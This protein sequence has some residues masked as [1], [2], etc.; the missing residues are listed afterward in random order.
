MP[1]VPEQ[2][3]HLNGTELNQF[4]QTSLEEHSNAI[5]FIAAEEKRV[6]LENAAAENKAAVVL[7][8]KSTKIKKRGREIGDEIFLGKNAIQEGIKNYSSLTNAGNN[9]IFSLPV[10]L[11]NVNWVGA[12]TRKKYNRAESAEVLTTCLHGKVVEACDECKDAPSDQ[13]VGDNDKIKTKKVHTCIHGNPGNNCKVCRKSK[14]ACP[15]NRFKSSCISCRGSRTC[16]HG[17]IKT[18]CKECGGSAICTHNRVK[19]TCKECGGSALCHH[20]RCKYYCKDCGGSALCIHGKIKRLCASCGGSALCRHGKLKYICKQCGIFQCQHGKRGDRC[21][22]C[23]GKFHCEH[24]QIRSKCELCKG[25]LILCEH[26]NL[27][28]QCDN[29]AVIQSF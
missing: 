26:G 27:K 17:R 23:G 18:V 20:G 15:H 19:Y 5:R 25:T 29:C 2:I 1:L 4:L 9:I 21:K 3:Q 11:S 14:N 24:F 28:R 6:A 13:Q 8:M 10:V 7:A 16:P 12:K 22:E